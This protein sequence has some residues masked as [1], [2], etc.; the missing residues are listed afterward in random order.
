M[1]AR[2]WDLLLYGKSGVFAAVRARR[3]DIY[4]T[5]RREAGCDHVKLLSDKR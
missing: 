2:D 4:F 1:R 3:L 5:P